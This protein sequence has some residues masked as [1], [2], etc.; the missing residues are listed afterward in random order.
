[1][2]PSRSQTN[3]FAPAGSCRLTLSFSSSRIR[4][5]GVDSP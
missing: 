1:L 4:P 5:M 3:D 2:S